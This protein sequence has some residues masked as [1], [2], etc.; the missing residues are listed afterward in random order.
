M[1]K[2]IEVLLVVLSGLG[3]GLLVVI[4]PP[5]AGTVLLGLVLA[6]AAMMIWRMTR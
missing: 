5:A 1:S 3:L 4:D 2:P 6:L